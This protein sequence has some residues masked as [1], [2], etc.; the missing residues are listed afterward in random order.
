MPREGYMHDV[1]LGKPV[2]DADMARVFIDHPDLVT[3]CLQMLRNKAAEIER[4]GRQPP[5]TNV[6]DDFRAYHDGGADAL[7]EVFW[8]LKRLSTRPPAE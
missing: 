6:R 3:M 5:I 8:E 7:E 2:D 1:D 4:T